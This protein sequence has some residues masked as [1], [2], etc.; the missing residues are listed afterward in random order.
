M[1]AHRL[2]N[3]LTVHDLRRAMDGVFTI[4]EA[5]KYAGC[6][7]ATVRRAFEAREISGYWHKPIGRLLLK[8]SVAEWA[9][10]RNK[11]KLGSA[12]RRDQAAAR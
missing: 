10:E 9:I 6:H 8:T 2:V 11:A 1:S 5:A 7:S 4:E 12:K 3:M